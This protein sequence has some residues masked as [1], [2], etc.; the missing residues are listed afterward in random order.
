MSRATREAYRDRLLPLLDRHP[1]V[2][3]LDTDTGLFKAEH[4]ARAGGQYLNLGI[5]EHNLMGIAAGMAA[6]LCVVGAAGL[7]AHA[8]YDRPR[9]LATGADYVFVNGVIVWP[10]PD[11]GPR[12]PGQVVS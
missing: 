10:H 7:T 6:D 9:A 4:A 8:S 2:I 5:A 12:R 3:C 11:A 1:D